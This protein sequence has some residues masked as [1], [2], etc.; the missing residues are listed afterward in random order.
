MTSSRSTWRTYMTHSHVKTNIMITQSNVCICLSFLVLY[1]CSPVF[2]QAWEGAILMLIHL[3]VLFCRKLEWRE[4]IANTECMH[5]CRNRSQNG[6]VVH[7]H[8][9]FRCRFFQS[10]RVTIAYIS[11]QYT[12]FA[13]IVFYSSIFVATIFDM[14]CA[15]LHSFM[16]WCQI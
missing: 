14:C 9:S 15:A 13:R 11:C 7:V 2:V 5:P 8:I 10:Q 16:C 1:I 6:I 3:Y 12:H 4:I